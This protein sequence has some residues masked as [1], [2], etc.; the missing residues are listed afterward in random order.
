MPSEIPSKIR[1]GATDYVVKSEVA[2]TRTD[3]C[4]GY[5]SVSN[6][7]IGVDPTIPRTRQKETLFHEVLHAV[8]NASGRGVTGKERVTEEEAIRAISD[9][10]LRTLRD[11][12]DFTNFVLEAD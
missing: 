2:G 8:W 11:N 5:M 9:G 6:A 4:N 12:P 1:V 7:L 3:G 10:L